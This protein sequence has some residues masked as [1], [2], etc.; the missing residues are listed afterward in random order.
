MWLR[1]A[2]APVC[3][4]HFWPRCQTVLRRVEW[5]RFVTSFLTWRKAHRGQ[6]VLMLPT[7]QFGLQCRPPPRWFQTFRCL[8]AANHLVA[9]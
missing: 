8:L 5:P 4:T 6:T 7:R 1:M 3:A 2:L 9:G